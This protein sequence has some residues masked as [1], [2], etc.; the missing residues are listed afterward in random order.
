MFTLWKSKATGNLA[1]GT[2]GA[3]SSPVQ[4]NCL[5]ESNDHGPM[6]FD[7]RGKN[8]DLMESPGESMING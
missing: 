6:D 4:S 1:L 7:S 5:M 2:L 8:V 3:K